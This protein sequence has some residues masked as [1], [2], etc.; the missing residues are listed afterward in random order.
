[1]AIN[2]FQF[3][4]NR[5]SRFSGNQRWNEHLQLARQNDQMVYVGFK[6]NNDH[7]LEKT[8]HMLYGM[9]QAQRDIETDANLTEAARTE[10]LNGLSWNLPDNEPLYRDLDTAKNGKHG[11]FMVIDPTWEKGEIVDF[12]TSPASGAQSVLSDHAYLMSGTM[13]G[14]HVGV[15]GKD[16]LEFLMGM[17]ILVGTAEHSDKTGVIYSQMRSKCVDD[18]GIELTVFG[19]KEAAELYQKETLAVWQKNGAN[20]NLTAKF[21]ALDILEITSEVVNGFGTV[22]HTPE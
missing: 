21:A 7:R 20:P 6:V 14:Y 1:M 5:I 12:L 2:M 10:K 19:T 13:K 8:I 9:R 18:G 3:A 16:T 11:G 4:T 17:H 15:N 22:Y